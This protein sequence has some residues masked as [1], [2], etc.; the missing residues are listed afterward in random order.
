MLNLFMAFCVFGFFLFCCHASIPWFL[1]LVLEAFWFYNCSHFSFLLI[2]MISCVES[3]VLSLSK[4]PCVAIVASVEVWQAT[5]SAVAFPFVQLLPH[6]LSRLS[7]IRL[8]LSSM[9]Q[10]CIGISLAASL[11]LSHACRWFDPIQ[12]SSGSDW[13]MAA[14]GQL[15]S[16]LKMPWLHPH[17]HFP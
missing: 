8:G 10:V 16:L 12:L 1:R 9:F 2:S 17:L 11:S 7:L 14:A 6:L 5:L 13:L 3:L 15:Q 4:L